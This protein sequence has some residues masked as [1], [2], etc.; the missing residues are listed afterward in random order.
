MLLQSF[1]SA[2]YCN[3]LQTATLAS[4]G[5]SQSSWGPG[6]AKSSV[7]GVLTELCHAMLAP[8]T[9]ALVASTHVAC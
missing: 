6:S 3:Y 4:A 2:T 8:D 9:A 5:R 1:R 7:H